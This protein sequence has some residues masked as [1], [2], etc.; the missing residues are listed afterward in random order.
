M[1]NPQIQQNRLDATAP[2]EY[3]GGGRDT[4]WG[5]KYQASNIRAGVKGAKSGSDQDIVNQV[6]KKGQGPSNVKGLQTAKVKAIKRR[7]NSM[8]SRLSDKAGV[9]R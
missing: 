9:T 1:A 7:A 4:T 8:G 6:Y 2:G 3:V 5:E